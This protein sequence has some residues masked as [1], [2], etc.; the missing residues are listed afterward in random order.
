MID[1]YTFIHRF[2]IDLISFE[3][4]EVRG[5]QRLYLSLSLRDQQKQPLVSHE[6]QRILVHEGNFKPY[7]F[8]MLVQMTER[9]PR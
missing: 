4:C 3:V 6:S 2:W 1:V 5:S 7:S 8:D 9:I